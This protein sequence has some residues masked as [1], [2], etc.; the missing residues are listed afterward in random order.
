DA[1]ELQRNRQR[2][3]AVQSNFDIVLL[4]RL[5]AGE[6]DFDRVAPGRKAEE[7]IVPVR[8]RNLRLGALQ[9]WTRHRDGG[10]RERSPLG[11]QNLTQNPPR[12]LGE[13]ARRDE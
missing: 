3:R 9:V 6:L 5:E 7:T 11:V 2:D 12:R 13:R 8:I 10:P 1:R 4:E